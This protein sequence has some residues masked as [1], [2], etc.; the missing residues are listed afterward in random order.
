MS[1]DH[2]RATLAAWDEHCDLPDAVALHLDEC[3]V[4]MVAF[5]AR[6]APPPVVTSRRRSPWVLAVAAAA[7][8][9]AGLALP[10]ADTPDLDPEPAVCIDLEVWVPPECPA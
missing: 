4:C 1:C 6:F 5:D 2:T 7:L 8:I 3:D 10:V 9:A